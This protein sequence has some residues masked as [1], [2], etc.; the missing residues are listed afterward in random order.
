MNVFFL[1]EVLII[2]EK[3]ILIGR[4]IICNDYITTA[5][6]FISNRKKWFLVIEVPVLY[7]YGIILLYKNKN[8]PYNLKEKNNL[9]GLLAKSIF[10]LKY[11]EN[12]FYFIF[13]VKIQLLYW[14]KCGF[15]KK[16]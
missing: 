9:T 8:T 5:V 15:K 12:H 4:I 16:N 10:K 1:K 13:F 11:L 6:R 3:G 7:F 14:Q 2:C